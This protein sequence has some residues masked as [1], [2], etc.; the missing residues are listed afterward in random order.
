MKPMRLTFKAGERFYLNGAVVHFPEKTT[1]ELLNKADFLL[2]SHIMQLDQTS[3]PLRQLYFIAQMMLTSPASSVDARK[4]FMRFARSLSQTVDH[5]R[6]CA[7]LQ[8]VVDLVNLGNVY[9][10]MK[11]IRELYPLE[12]SLMNDVV[13]IKDMRQTELG[14][15]A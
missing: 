9:E 4:T 14:A 15:T 7:G 5:Y 2:E 13:D 6:L 1:L 12:D 11:K 8:E 3:T 10:A